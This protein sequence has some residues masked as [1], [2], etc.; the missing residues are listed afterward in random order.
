M[1]PCCLQD[2]KIFTTILSYFLI[3]SMWPNGLWHTGLLNKKIVDILPPEVI[4][5]LKNKVTTNVLFNPSMQSY[6]STMPVWIFMQVDSLLLMSHTGK[7]TPSVYYLFQPPY[8]GLVYFL[9]H[10]LHQRCL[11]KCALS[12]TLL[13]EI[14]VKYN[15]CVNLQ[16]DF[17]T[18]KGMYTHWLFNHLQ[19]FHV[20]R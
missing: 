10:Y 20:S 4:Q 6:K 19:L 8:S 15:A 3:F 7:S 1:L 17:D 12:K 16:L 14:T 5:E 9:T 18:E 11:C 2:L 13:G